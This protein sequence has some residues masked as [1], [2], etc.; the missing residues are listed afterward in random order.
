MNVTKANL[1]LYA[2]TTS[3]AN[4]DSQVEKAI[5]GGATFIQLR[6]KDLTFSQFLSLAKKVKKVTDKYKIPFVINDNVEV[7]VAVNADGVHLGQSDLQLVEAR[8]VLGANKIIGVSAQ[9]LEEALKAQRNGADYIGVG[10]MFKTTSKCDASYVSVEQLS[11]ICNGVTIPVV[12]IGGINKN[13][14]STLSRSGISGVA[15]ISAIFNANDIRNST[16]ELLKILKKY[17]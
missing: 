15:V 14:I 4:V 13:N 9:T 11:E 5:L 10:A 1:L 17:L 7:A 6:A 2:V 12:A 16:E 3:D 8:N